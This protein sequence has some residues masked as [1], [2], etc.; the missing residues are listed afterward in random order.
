MTVATDCGALLHAACQAVDDAR[1][2]TL[3]A[4]HSGHNVSFD[5]KASATATDIDPVT[6]AD[7]QCEALIRRVL[8]K[9]APVAD[10]VGEESA[11][12]SS[13]GIA[14]DGLTW[15]VDP[16]DGTRAFVCGIPTWSTLIALYCDARP[17]FGVVDFPALDE[18]YIGFG[19][20]ARRT[21]AGRETALSVRT[22]VRLPQAILCCTTPDMFTTPDQVGAFHR[23]RDAVGMTRFGTDAYGYA[24][25]AT[26]QVDVVVE[27]DLKPWDVAAVASLVR[28]AGGVIT[29]WNGSD[30]I[31]SDKIVAAGDVG[32]HEHLLRLLANP[33]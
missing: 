5:N 21:V 17:V 19:D 14:R 28:A 12:A 29:D 10:F 20:Q 30:A 27:A 26:G 25:L 7:R 13:T 3:G 15:I 31:L 18:R 1:A 6:D 9:A 33:A 32:V 11:A 16:I 23:V 24:M 2:V 22:D 8:G 4:F